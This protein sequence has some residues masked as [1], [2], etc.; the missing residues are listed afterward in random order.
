[1]GDRQPLQL[2]SRQVLHLDDRVAQRVVP[3]SL[4][5]ALDHALDLM[6]ALHLLAKVQEGI[7]LP[8]M[9]V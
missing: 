5:P 3:P 2:G 7:D 8:V 4:Q 1:M 6:G 9:C